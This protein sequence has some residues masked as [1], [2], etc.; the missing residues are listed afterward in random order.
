MK[1][2]FSRFHAFV[3]T[4]LILM[5]IIDQVTK[6]AAIKYLKGKPS[7]HFPSSWTPNDLFRL[8]YTENT[9]AF[10]SL[11]S[12]L[13]ESLRFWLFTVMNTVVL[14][15][16]LF[17]IF[18]KQNLPHITMIS[19]SLIISGG[20]GNIIDRI[21]RDGRVID[22]MNIGIGFGSWSLRTGIFNVADLAIV[23]GLILLLI[24]EFTSLGNTN[25]ST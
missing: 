4:L 3:L 8:T 10:L 24:G 18:Y 20:V 12:Q 2:Y 23:F 1:L 6:V 5:L 9:G 22:F 11:G 7:I 19:F 17:L 14:A 13:P 16:L 21:F 25:I 15:I